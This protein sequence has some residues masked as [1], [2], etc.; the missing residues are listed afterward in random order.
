[1][2]SKRALITGITGQDGSYLTELLL[3]K[4]YEVH[5]TTR[6]LTSSQSAAFR[7]LIQ[8]EQ[9][10]LS[11]V[12]LH[13]CDLTSLEQVSRLCLA[14]EPHEIY[15]LA[16]QSHVGRSFEFPLETLQAN[17][18][19]TLTLLEAVRSLQ[20]QGCE[21]RFYQASSSEMFG[22]PAQY[23]QTEQTPFH[24]RSPYACSKVYAYHQVANYREAHGLFVCNGILYNHESPRRSEAYVT[25]KITL[26]A[27]RISLG[28]QN[29]LTLGNLD[30]G[31]DW[32][33]AKEYVLAMWK[34][35]QHDEPDDYIIA[36][37]Q[38]HTLEEFLERAFKRVNLH[39]QDHVD[40][41]PKLLRPVEVTRL[42]GDY[43]K[44][45]TKLNWQPQTGF[46][47]LVDLM[48]DAD[49]QYAASEL[50]KH[51]VVPVINR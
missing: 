39:W 34:M 29:K 48:I 4:G 3:G 49:L 46:A 28:L 51:S 20:Q 43:S 32:G 2:T 6:S 23:P 21:V 45:H 18:Q 30:V 19:A 35:L 44:A 11:T 7:S 8:A 13:E 12:K 15:H 22:V 27:A 10:N 14:I 33:Y 1:M 38:W 17:A 36:T 42:Q 31:R 50:P 16:A 25:R 37:N 5:G 9:Q 40:Q 41:D 24:P 26:A 47:E